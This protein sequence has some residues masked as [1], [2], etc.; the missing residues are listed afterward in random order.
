MGFHEIF[1]EATYQWPFADQL[2]MKDLIRKV[3]VSPRERT[4]STTAT[5][6][7]AKRMGTSFGGTPLVFAY[8]NR[9]RLPHI[10]CMQRE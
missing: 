3:C 9:T 8:L 5:V 4:W 6:T 7:L 1:N 10:D 2:T